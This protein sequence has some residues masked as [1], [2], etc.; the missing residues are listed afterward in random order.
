MVMS[1]QAVV[2]QF[3]LFYI[4]YLRESSAH[5]CRGFLRPKSGAKQVPIRTSGCEKQRITVM[6]GITA[7]RQTSTILNL[8]KENTS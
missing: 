5:P 2:F 3:S 1:D 4:P 6:L 7:V 8:Q